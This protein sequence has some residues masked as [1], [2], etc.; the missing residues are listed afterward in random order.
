M[1]SIAWFYLVTN[2]ARIITYVP[3]IIAVARAT[4]GA[5]SL[6]LIT[7]GSWVVSHLAALLYATLVQQDS[8]FAFVSALNMV[9][10]L[11]VFWITMSKRLSRHRVQ[12]SLA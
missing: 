7:W 2:S 10:T 3:Q 6:S 9:C 4:D 1:A 12:R 5:R 11:T 8:F